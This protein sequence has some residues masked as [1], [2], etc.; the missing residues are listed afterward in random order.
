MKKFEKINKGTK[1]Y[2]INIA[3]AIDAMPKIWLLNI[4]VATRLRD[5]MAL[6]TNQPPMILKATLIK[7]VTY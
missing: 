7:D 6:V 4:N 2:S 1:L 3:P 5:H